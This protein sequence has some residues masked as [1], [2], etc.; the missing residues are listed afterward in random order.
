M[1][2]SEW[3]DLTEEMISAAADLLFEWRLHW[4]DLKTED[5][6]VKE[7]WTFLCDAQRE[8]CMGLAKHASQK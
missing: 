1:N 2:K 7:L 6:V 5:E 3:P 4:S 8:Q